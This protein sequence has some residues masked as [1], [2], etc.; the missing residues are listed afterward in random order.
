MGFTAAWL[1]HE[2]KTEKLQKVHQ[3]YAGVRASLGL[4][5][6]KF[7]IHVHRGCL[8]IEL[9]SLLNSFNPYHFSIVCGSIVLKSS[10][11]LANDARVL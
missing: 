10:A 9:Q 5:D 8:E 6:E 3:F 2:T 1:G 4:K 11:V 7:V